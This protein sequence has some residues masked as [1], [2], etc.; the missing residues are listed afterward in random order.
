MDNLKELKELASNLVVLYTEDDSDIAGTMT[1]YLAKF[2]K[3]VVYAVNGE[4]GLNLYKE[5]EFDLVIT[6]IRMPKMN[7]LD[8]SYEIKQINPNQNIIII[9]AYSEIENFV[10]SI[11]LGIDGYI[12]KP[13]NYVD[14]NN[15]LYKMA[16]KITI[17]KK[18]ARFEE[19]LKSLVSQLKD[20]NEELK[21]YTDALN[22][23]AIVSKTNTAGQITFVNELFCEISG[24][25]KEELIGKNHNIVRHPDT[26]KSIFK[27]LWDTIKEGKIWEGN[28]KNKS[29]NGEAFYIHLTII[30][31]INSETQKIQEYIAIR[32]L[33][34]KEEMEKREFKRA[35]M[36]NYQELRKENF[37]A[38]KRIENLE[39]EIVA[40]QSENN[41]IEVYKEKQKKL[42][43]QI[44]YFEKEIE[45]L[46]DKH[47]KYTTS[48]NDMLILNQRYAKKIETQKEE[49]RFLKMQTELGKKEILKLEEKVIDQKRI[50]NDYKYIIKETKESVNK[51]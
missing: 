4:D 38:N 49:I 39:Q 40:Y 32:F 16:K 1:S 25:S 13:V 7:G 17:F 50:I 46:K 8:M 51:K 12:I 18:N 19:Q 27:N 6:D 11:K 23:V 5:G 21:H 10:S 3:E 20:K 43:S 9:S 47:L 24:Y 48:A 34:T 26:D 33:T 29:K 2:F 35:V 30:P 41:Q 28:L 31:L 42:L 37:N 22:K 44:A 45:K 36:F 14:M 15:L